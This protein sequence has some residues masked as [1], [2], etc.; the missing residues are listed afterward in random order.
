MT[1]RS[2]HTVRGIWGQVAGLLVLAVKVSAQSA[3]PSLALS[4]SVAG[5]PPGGTTQIRIFASTPQLVTNGGF[6]MNLD[7]AVFGSVT[8]AAV[9]SATG[10]AVGYAS[11]SAGQGSGQ[12]ASGS[13]L[14][15]S[16][17]S[18][19]GGIAQ[20]PGLP[21]FVITVPVSSSAVI[22]TTSTINLDPSGSAWND[23]QGNVYTVTAAPATFTVAGTLSIQSVTPGGGLLPSGTTVTISGTG[24]DAGATVAID[25]VAI[26]STKFVSP[27]QIAVVLDGAYEMTARH[28]HLQMSSGAQADF[29]CS[30]SSVPA[31]VTTP[32]VFPL[33]PL[34][35]Y[36]NVGWGYPFGS[37]MVEDFAALQNQNL[38]PV[39]VTFFYSRGF[40]GIVIVAPSITIPPGELYLLET[41][42][43]ASGLGSLQMLSSAPMRMLQVS[44]LEGPI[45]FQAGVSPPSPLTVQQITALLQPTAYVATNSWTWQIGSPPP[46]PVQIELMGGFPFTATVSASW[47]SVSPT[48][49]TEPAALL[50]TPNV[51]GLSA[52]TYTGAVTIKTTLPPSLSSVTIQDVVVPVTLQVSASPFISA[53]GDAYFPVTVGTTAAVTGTFSVTSS[54]TPAQFSTSVNTSSGGNWLSVTPAS[55]TTPGPITVTA[56]PSGLPV[57]NYLGNVM[58]QGPV[59]SIAYSVRLAISPPTPTGPVPLSANPTSLTFVLVPGT[60]AGIMAPPA[61]VFVQPTSNFTISVQTQS[62]GSWLTATLI[63]GVVSVTAS[64]VGLNAGT[65]LGTVALTSTTNGSVQIPVTLSVLVPSSS[66]LTVT[67]SSV[68]LTLQAGQ[69]GTQT[70]NVSSPAS[71]PFGVTTLEPGGQQWMSDSGPYYTPSPIILTFLSTQPGTHYGNVTVTSGSGSVTVPVVLTVTASAGSPPILGSIVSAASGTPSAISPGDIITLYGSGIGSTPAGLTLGTNGK[72]VTNLGGTQLIIGGVAAPIVYQSANQVNAI[73]PYE[74]VSDEVASGGVTT[75]QLIA[76]GVSSPTWSVPLAP[77]APA[78]FTTGSTGIGQGALL[79][80]DSSVNSAS[81]PA[82]A[83][84]VVQIFATGGGQTSPASITGGV[85]NSAENS[86]LPVTVTIDGQNAVV[87][88][89]GS[90]PDEVSG[91]LQVNAV[92]PAGASSGSDSLTLTINGQKS[93]PGVTIAVK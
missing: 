16:F 67:P 45:I 73:V 7:P 80:Q 48:Q 11:L 44:Q 55:G 77:A 39:T 23:S 6:S 28:V 37:G 24:F 83:G 19:S 72:V 43:Y 49:G 8:N 68:A 3:A 30:L 31:N 70:L 79:N 21:I 61:L 89:Q 63:G 69:T 93:Q 25:G 54:G 85:A 57:G 9:F 88:Y 20:L 41:S 17:S 53:I 59:N 5:A 58:I 60:P 82:I 86:L 14:N 42:S 92:I 56:N 15:A 50:L 47:L 10:D 51:S 13:Q 36:Q 62:G 34:N 52:G 4:I 76:S 29:F 78:I 91:L 75:V 65:Y 22:G 38:T 27:Q 33:L 1:G 74:I 90:A 71:T 32:T 87:T 66:P 35:T 81:N 18:P 12:G 84:T 26:S 64:S 2:C 46:G 40:P